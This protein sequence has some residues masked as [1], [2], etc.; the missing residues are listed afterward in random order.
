MYIRPTSM[1]KYSFCLN[2]NIVQ[3]LY[4]YGF[5]IIYNMLAI[6]RGTVLFLVLLDLAPVFDTVDLI[7]L[8]DVIKHYIGTDGTAYESMVFK[9]LRLHWAA[10]NLV[11]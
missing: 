5:I 10:V 8:V 1:S 2:T 3:R 4:S 7:I 9:A 6:D 11:K